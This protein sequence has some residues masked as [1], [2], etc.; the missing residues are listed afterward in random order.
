MDD[1]GR[2]VLAFFGFKNN[3]LFDPILLL[4]KLVEMMLLKEDAFR[5]EFA[6]MKVV[7]M[8]VIAQK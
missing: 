5:I 8:V 6:R 4:R 2:N 7:M 1:D 3:L